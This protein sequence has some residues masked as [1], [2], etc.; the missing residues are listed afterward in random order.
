M[1]FVIH[2]HTKEIY[3]SKP[4][5][6]QRF[7]YRTFLGR[8]ILRILISPFVSKISGAYM[9]SFLSRMHIRRFIKKN[10]IFMEDYKE[11]RFTSF[12]AFFTRKIKEDK[13]PIEKNPNV[14]IS[15]CDAKLSVYKIE[16]DS[17]FYIKNS[18]YRLD[19]LLENKTLA[20]EYQNGYCL[21][22]RLGVDD[23][24]RYCYMDDGS[25]EKNIS[26]KGVFHTVH[27][28]S[29]EKYNFF[30]KNHRI[31]TIL[32]TLHFGDIVQVEVGAM[33]VGKIKNH[34]EDYTFTRGEEK[35]YFMFGGSTIVL[36]VKDIIEIDEDIL[37]AS[38]QNKEMTIR[39]GER[40][41]VLK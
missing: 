36:L 31:Y 35:G 9:S 30:K 22:F 34:Y 26:I 2:R 25:Q 29:L 21:I 23:Y 12:N 28:I 5:I 6:S 41:G 8:I 37:I 38:Q 4:S 20:M 39:Y 15:P 3:E 33:M 1:S 14:L 16:E 19:D 17:I 11:E 10:H 27:P 7:L 32:H 18:Y 40:V 13:R 24:H